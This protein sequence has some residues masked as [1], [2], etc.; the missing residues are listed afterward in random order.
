MAL[1]W[2]ASKLEEGGR[3]REGGGRESDAEAMAEGGGA[4]PVRC[5]ADKG[6]QCCPVAPEVQRARLRKGLTERA[7]QEAAAPCG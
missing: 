2:W 1:A 6:E 4:E 3:V 5:S 7:R